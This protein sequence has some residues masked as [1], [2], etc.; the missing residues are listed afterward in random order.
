M[1]NDTESILVSLRTRVNEQGDLVSDLT[2]NGEPELDIKKGI[3]ELKIRK[4]ALK[5]KEMESIGE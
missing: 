4:K 2:A 5:E 3:I 1:P